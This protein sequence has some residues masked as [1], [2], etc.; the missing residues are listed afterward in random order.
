MGW[1]I[2]YWTL[3]GLGAVSVRLGGRWHLQRRPGNP[4]CFAPSCTAHSVLA[5]WL[6]APCLRG[7]CG[8]V[9][10]L[11]WAPCVSVRVGGNQRRPRQPYLFSPS[12]AARFFLHQEKL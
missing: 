6:L 11:A 2:S 3:A 7:C 5:R 9:G 4:T 1:G 8:G 10:A 12:C